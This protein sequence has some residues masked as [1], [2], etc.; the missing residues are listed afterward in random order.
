MT[1]DPDRTSRHGLDPLFRPTSIAVIGA[2]A[3]A[4]RIGGRP[5]A[6][7]L[8][9]GFAG[10][11]YPINPGQPTV[12]GLPAFASLDDVPGPVDQA[13]V[14]L[15]AVHAEAAVESCLRKGVKAIVMFTAGLGE[16]GGHG[17][18]L[19]ARIAAR[20]RAAGTRLLGPNS[21]GLFCPA[22]RVFSTFSA[23]FDTRWPI[24][25]PIAIASQSGAIGSY[26]FAGL[27]DRGLGVSR[28]VATGNEADVDIAACIDW[29]ADDDATQ[30]IA[31]YLEGCPDGR[32]LRT[33][34]RKA[35]LGGKKVVV[36]KVG[37]SDSGAAAVASHTGALAGS[38][39]AFAAVLAET[40]AYRAQSVR[41]FV[42]VAMACARLPLPAGRRVG[43]VT[44]SGGAGV[45]LA[46]AAAACGMTVPPLPAGAQSAIGALVPFASAANPVDSTAQVANDPTLL[47]RVLDIMLA[48]DGFDTLIGFLA[49][50]G[51]DEALMRALRPSLLALRRRFPRRPF[52]LVMRSLPQVRSELEPEGILVV[53]EPTDAIRIAAA[54]ARLGEPLDATPPPAPPRAAPLPAGPIDEAA[55]KRALARF[56]VPFLP[57]RAAAT[58]DEALSAARELSWPVALKVLADG[59]AHKSDLGGVRLGLRDEAELRAAWRGMMQT[60][61]E[62]APHVSP[63]GALVAPMLTGGVETVI[64]GYQDP[65]FGPMAM[66]GLGGLFVEV[67]RDVVFRPAPVTRAGARAMIDAIRGR[68]VLAGLRGQPPADLDALAAA[69][70]AVANFLA[71]H[72]TTVSSVE[73]NPFTVLPRGGF[74]LDA[75]IVPREGRPTWNPGST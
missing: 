20:C 8:R 68:A 64:G 9:A 26:C 49:H 36:L 45:M 37:V 17:Q 16:V 1:S 70:V 24:P 53:D 62:R 51:R 10:P 43:I 60:V 50:M 5:V 67:F 69:I 48:A 12:A 47:P 44:V 13:V 18:A 54:L 35:T 57:E 42:Q 59:I 7:L 19:Q 31:A 28:F 34:L 41:E 4:A 52:L 27:D 21:L 14:A 15:A 75:L 29:L 73:L 65:V 33:A 6:S 30:V 58:E 2:S 66:F 39:A 61:A 74:A 71:A 11:I 32:R 72:E 25:G 38:D 3:N 22:D 46:D 40:G 63:K 23:A 56:G 55:A